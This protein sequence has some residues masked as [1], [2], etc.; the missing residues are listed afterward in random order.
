MLRTRVP[1]LALAL[2]VLAAACAPI[3]SDSDQLAETDSA[4]NSVGNFG[5]NPG[6]LK[7]NLY[8]PTGMPQNAPVVVAMHG[9]SM[10]A[11][12]YVKAGWNQLADQWKF[13]VVYPEQSSAT[14]CFNWYDGTNTARGSGE[15]L[16]IKQMVDHM[17]SAY[18]VDPGR[19]FVTG[20]S[21]GGAMTA[22][23][24]ATYPDVFAVM[25]GIPYRC[26]SV[27]NLGSC[28]ASKVEQTPAAWGNLVRNAYPGYQGPRPRLSICTAPRTPSS[29]R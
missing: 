12:D 9:C 25:A 18:S 19:V 24:L 21:A 7:M 15:A 10:T 5:S 26:A 17:K 14:R 20:L 29:I 2:T 27:S 1:A 22:V 28:M 16:S 13:Y 6:N 11:Q 4:L 3:E 8:V 23:M